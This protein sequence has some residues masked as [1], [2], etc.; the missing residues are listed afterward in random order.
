MHLACL[1]FGRDYILYIIYNFGGWVIFWGGAVVV[2]GGAGFG[3]VSVTDS[4][5]QLLIAA[6]D[7]YGSW[8]GRDLS[9]ILEA[10]RRI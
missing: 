1:F 4:G 2:L 3:G 10:G 9:E 6:I 5:C 8:M 7:S